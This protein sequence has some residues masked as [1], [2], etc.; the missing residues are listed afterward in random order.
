[1]NADANK[2]RTLFLAAV[3]QHTP[4]QWAAYLE[5]ACAGDEDLR[6]RVAVLLKAHAEANSLLDHLAPD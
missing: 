4:D 1:M 3:E 5:E 2:V 6:Q